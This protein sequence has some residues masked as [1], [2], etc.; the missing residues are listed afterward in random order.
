MT[1]LTLAEKIAQ[2]PGEDGWWKSYS[3]ERF[4]GLADRLIALGM[5]ED[6]TVSFLTTAYY[7]VSNCYGN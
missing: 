4:N 5:S 3:E 6:E 2:I 1:D 7:A